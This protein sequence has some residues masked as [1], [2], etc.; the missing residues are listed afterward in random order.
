MP[1]SEAYI[2]FNPHVTPEPHFKPGYTGYL[3]GYGPHR[4][5]LPP[6]TFGKATHELL[7]PHPIA[8][9][10]LNTILEV[11][12]AELMAKQEQEFYLYQHQRYTKDLKRRKDTI[13]GYVGHIPRTRNIIGQAFPKAVRKGTAEFYKIR[14]MKLKSQ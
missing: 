1:R 2:N 11:P 10:R 12:T 4:L 5:Y 13:P 14:S 7:L 8:G 9:Y 3:P 6:K